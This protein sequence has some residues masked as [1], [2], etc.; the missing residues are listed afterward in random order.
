MSRRPVRI[1]FLGYGAITHDVLSY[2]EPE[3][4]LGAVEIA[5]AIVR[6]DTHREATVKLMT[7]DAAATK[8]TEVDAVVECA[9][10][11]AAAEFGPQ[12]IRSGLP[13]VLTSVGLLAQDNIAAQLLAG[14]G[15]LT[16]TNGAI[17]GF[18][19]L[20]ATAECAGFDAV[21]IRT[22]KH[23]PTLVQP[24]MPDDEREQLEAMTPDDG[25]LTIFSGSPRDAIERFPANVNVA[26]ALAWITRERDF[27]VASAA[28]GE[29]EKH[30]VATLE[31]AV[32]EIAALERSFQRVTVEIV[33]RGVNDPSSHHIHASG[34]AGTYEFQ[35]QSEASASNPRSSSLTAMSVTRNVREL[36]T[37]LQNDA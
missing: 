31:H 12:V 22:G 36:I 25:D 28:L 18:D 11:D 24:W 20:E 13:L 14:P 26:V 10:V 6:G 37:A 17:G 21:S 5:G 8:L 27:S 35:L 33:A 2:L 30:S 16:V 23:A 29:E 3:I 19:A 9:G 34:P 32:A 15:R 7:Q 1:L 4:Q